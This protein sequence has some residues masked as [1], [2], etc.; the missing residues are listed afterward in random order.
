MSRIAYLSRLEILMDGLTDAELKMLVAYSE[1]LKIGINR[2]NELPNL[3][4]IR[5]TP[6]TAFP[7]YDRQVRLLCNEV[8]W[9]ER[10]LAKR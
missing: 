7:E 1:R 8:E 9:L 10:E 2:P 3:E 4:A 6:G 5:N